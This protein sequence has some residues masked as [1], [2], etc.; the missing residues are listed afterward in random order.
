MQGIR[1]NPKFTA[2]Y[3]GNA[4]YEK[5]TLSTGKFLALR[6]LE[7]SRF[8]KHPLIIEQSS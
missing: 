4:M 3:V 7:R 6:K 2:I 5:G 1:A 8:P